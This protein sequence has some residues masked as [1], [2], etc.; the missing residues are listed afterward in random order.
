MFLPP[1]P[2]RTHRP[3]GAGLRNYLIAT[4]VLAGLV[5]AGL[6]GCQPEAIETY[7]T[8]RTKTPPAKVRLLG[9]ILP[10]GDATWFIKLVGPLAGLETHEAAFNDFLHSIQFPDKAAEADYLEDAARLG[11]AA[12]QC[13]SLC[14][15]SVRSPRGTSGGDHQQAWPRRR[16]GFGAGQRQSLAAQ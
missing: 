8:P 11:G 6:P 2:I 3:R 16:G 12:R 14:H 15:A 1:S 10:H 7:R 5:I 13:F 4:F 9:A